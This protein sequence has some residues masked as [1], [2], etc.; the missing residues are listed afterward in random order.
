MIIS[1]L[2]AIIDRTIRATL[3]ADFFA[4]TRQVGLLLDLGCGQRPYRFIY[5]AHCRRSLG[6]DLPGAPFP[7]AG[8]DIECFATDVPLESGSVDVILCS[9]VMQDI[10]EPADLVREAWRLLRPG[11]TLL[12]TTPFMVP[13]ADGPYDHYRFTEH[14]LR[15]LLGRQ[16]FAIRRIDTVGDNFGTL[17]AFFVK[18]QLKLWNYLAKGVRLPVIYS[19][20]NPFIFLLVFLPQ[21]LYLGLYYLSRRVRFLRRLLGKF[22]HGPLGYVVVADKPAAVT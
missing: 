7:R 16:G 14:G 5:D 12:L 19:L 17:V 15:Y 13:I 9:E 22:S 1:R 21:A 2:G 11:G 8:V 3:L 20:W 4:G 18:P 10:A 6:A